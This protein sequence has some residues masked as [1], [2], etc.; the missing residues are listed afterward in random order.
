MITLLLDLAGLAA[1]LLSYHDYKAELGRAICSQGERPGGC[2]LVYMIPQAYIAGRIHLSQL[3][4]VYFALLTLLDAASTILHGDP[5]RLAYMLSTILVYLG[6]IM[7]PYLVYLEL[8]VARAVC[9]WCT[10]MHIIIVIQAVLR[11]D[12][13]L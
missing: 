5:A 12:T 10:I 11:I 2:K 4:P 9:I 3:A 8:R 1:S 6:L 7:V 13:P